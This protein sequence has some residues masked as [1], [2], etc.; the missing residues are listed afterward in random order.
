MLEPG[1][2]Q[3]LP[4]EFVRKPYRFSDLVDAIHRA[5]ARCQPTSRC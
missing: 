5:L 3:S 1:R 2:L 4:V